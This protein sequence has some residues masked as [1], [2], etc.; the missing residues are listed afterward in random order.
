MK[1]ALGAKIALTALFISLSF[2]F[3]FP[4]AHAQETATPTESSDLPL[5]T[6]FALCGGN[7]LCQGSTV[8]GSLAGGAIESVA[9]NVGTVVLDAIAI[10]ILGFANLLL[11][12]AGSLFNLAMV[13]TVFQ[14]SIFLGNSPGLLLAWSILRDVGNILLLFGFIFIGIAMILDLHSY[15]AKKT[16][17]QL[18]I[19]AILMNFSLF[20]AEAV[21]DTTN[22]LSSVL[23]S[24]ANSDPC[25]TLFDGGGARESGSFE[26]AR[27]DLEA[28]CIVNTGIA[29]HIM[30]STGLGSIFDADDNGVQIGAAVMIGL[31]LFATIGAT[32]LFAGAIM[33]IVRAVMLMFLMISAPLGFAALAIPPLQ[34]YGKKWWTMLLHQSFFAPIFLLLIFASLKI[35]DTFAQSSGTS[36]SLAGALSQPN[37]SVMQ[38]FLVFFLICGM[39]IASLL[40]AKKVSTKAGFLGVDFAVRNATKFA[41]GGVNLG[42]SGTGRLGRMAALKSPLGK[43]PAVRAFTRMTLKPMQRGA[44]DMRKLPGMG[45]VLGKVGAGEAAAP[46]GDTYDYAAEKVRKFRK[47][48]KESS[49]EDETVVAINDLRHQLAA[50]NLSPESERLLA[51]LSADE[52]ASNTSLQN[53]IDNLAAHLSPDQFEGMMKSDKLGSSTK[54]KLSN[55]RFNNAVSAINGGYANRTTIRDLSSKDLEMLAKYNP[56]AFNNLL[57]QFD[58]ATGDSMLSNDQNE[59]LAKSSALTNTQRASVR[60]QSKVGRVEAAVTAGNP[61]AG[62]YAATMSAKA[63]AKLNTTALTNLGVIS[64]LNAGDLAEIQREGKL[65]PP[66]IN[67]ITRAVTSAT[68]PNSVAIQDWLANNANARGYW[69]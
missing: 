4:I 58:P 19:F 37:A 57:N 49:K 34:E 26:E 11:G 13:K 61:V 21:I 39:L 54:D 43:S 67:L 16:L 63:K 22:G 28:D 69:R 60:A 18:L 14:F 41:F 44:L 8:V 46:G 1:N 59:A 9:S 10:F 5:T 66:E 36:G 7:L 42:M 2:A 52:I 12:I 25:G 24:Q 65:S 15:P 6:E 31:A 51:S 29:G 30:Q 40:F 68:H 20:A 35:S 27:E 56:G 23:Y 47:E 48:M 33:L 62:T 38:I 50:G 53:S 45:A 55:A 3:A 32:V 64:T 17:P